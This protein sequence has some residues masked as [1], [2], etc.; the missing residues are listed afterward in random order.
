M[1]VDHII[2]QIKGGD[3]SLSNLE[4]MCIF[5]NNKKGSKSLAEFLETKY[6][7]QRGY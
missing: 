6:Y 3:S 4:P 1:T 2:P 7:P 5:C